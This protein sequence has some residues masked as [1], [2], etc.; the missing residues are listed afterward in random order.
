MEALLHELVG[1]SGPGQALL[2]R[3]ALERMVS[4]GF[5]VTTI[6]TLAL[7]VPGP[8]Q[9][10][11]VAGLI[12]RDTDGA[13][14]LLEASENSSVELS[15]VVRALLV[16]IDYLEAHGRTTTLSMALGYLACCEEAPGVGEQVGAL[17]DRVREHLEDH[18]FDG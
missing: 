12:G 14:R 10:S 17:A 4:L 9:L 1:L 16:L 8:R 6:R 5:D 2:W 13:A 18:G 7:A 15:S 11:S 3:N